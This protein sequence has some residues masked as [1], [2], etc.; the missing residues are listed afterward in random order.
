M[1]VITLSKVPNSLRGDLTR[2]CQEVQTGVYVGNFSARIRELLWQK[3]KQNVGQGEATI[4]YSTNNELGYTFETTRNSYEVV[5]FDGIPLMRRLKEDNAVIKLGYSKAA[6]A[7][8]ARI[9]AQR[10]LRRNF[11]TDFV[12]LDIETTGV[13]IFKDEILSV[14]AIKIQNGQQFEFY[15]LVKGTKD[16]PQKITQLT[17]LNAEKINS[18]GK[19]ISEVLKELFEFIGDMTIIGYN[20]NFDIDFLN[21][22]YERENLTKLTNKTLDLLLLVKKQQRFLDNYRLETVLQKFAIQNKQPHNALADAR[23]YIDLYDKLMKKDK[24]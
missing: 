9:M 17:G 20:L 19:N 13:D 11:C 10:N 24:L 23:T 16:I 22:F 15:S 4:I 1:I 18:E 3:I 14:G 2:W 6:K 12:A 5:N 21:K 8:K 7:H